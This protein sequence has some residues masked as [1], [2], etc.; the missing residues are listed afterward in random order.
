ML[1]RS[2]RPL[3][4]YEIMLKKVDELVRILELKVYSQD[5]DLL[6]LQHVT[7]IRKKLVGEIPADQQGEPDSGE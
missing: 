4:C 7:D 1:F 6:T 3:G 5:L 2:S